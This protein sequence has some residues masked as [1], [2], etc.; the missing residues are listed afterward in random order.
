[1]VDISL[2]SRLYAPF[3][4]VVQKANI[5]HTY[6]YVLQMYKN[7]TYVSRAKNGASISSPT[8]GLTLV[9]RTGAEIKAGKNKYAAGGHTQ[10]WEYAGPT[11]D[12]SW[13][14]GTKP[15]DDRWT[16]QIARV[17]YNSGRVSNNTQMAR[18][19][20]LVE[21]T[22]GDW[23]GKHIKRVEAAVSP[24]YKYLMIATVWTDNS[25]HFGLYELPK[26]NALLNGN[27][28]GNV[29]VSELKQCQAGEVIDIDN[30]V[31]RIG[32]IQG[33][34]IDDDLNVYVSSQYDPTH[35]DS[36]KR[37]IVKFSWEQPGALNTLD[38]TGD[39]RLNQNFAGYPTE[40]EGIQVI[41]NND[42]YLTVAYHNKNGVGTIG[43]QIFRV[44]W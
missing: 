18:I 36:N 28:G 19:S 40:L 38:L 3:A 13:F 7:N 29:T 33:Y 23:H 34:D 5:G 27:P 15:N 9:G 16:T 37:K 22:N 14:I 17:K 1:M 4:R 25:G 35:A 12:G 42:L 24:N 44:K 43:N 8:P 32:S 30:F 2:K 39:T 41:G 20:N 6:T 31:G 10:T 11:G 21:I 26:M